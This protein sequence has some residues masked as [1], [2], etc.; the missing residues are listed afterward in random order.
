MLYES[1]LR[2]VI[3]TRGPCETQ[4]RIEASTRRHHPTPG[5][6]FTILGTPEPRILHFLGAYIHLRI[7]LPYISTLISILDNTNLPE[8]LSY[9]SRR[10]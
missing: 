8:F 5:A 2:V 7:H 9:R 4:L 1:G 10:A 3:I 6:D